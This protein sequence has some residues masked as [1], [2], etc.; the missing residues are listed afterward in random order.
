MM[1]QNGRRQHAKSRNV[2]IRQA[3]MRFLHFR[4]LPKPGIDRFAAGFVQFPRFTKRGGKGEGFEG[5]GR[6]LGTIWEQFGIG[7]EQKYPGI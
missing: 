4:L 5:F 3:A 2:V 1:H 6:D 7:G